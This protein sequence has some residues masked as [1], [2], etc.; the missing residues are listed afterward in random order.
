MRKIH[1]ILRLHFEQKLGQRQ[2]ARSANV[3]Q[4]TVHDYLARMN[5]AGLR[6]PLDQEWDEDR[7]EQALFPPGQAA[8]KAPLRVQPDFVHVRQ[9]LEQHRDLTVELLWEEYREQHPDGYCYSRFCKLYRRWKKHQDVVLRQDHRPGE[10]LFLDWAGATIPIHHRDGT[11]TQAP[12]FVSALGVSSYTYAEAV[13]DQQMANWLKVQMNALEFYDGCPQLL[14]PDNTKT[15][16]TRACIYEPDLNPTYQ[17]FAIHYRV[18]VMPTRP[19]KPR[20]KACVSY[21]T[22]SRLRKG[23]SWLFSSSTA[24]AL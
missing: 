6:W 18:A 14:I 23:E 5:A 4:S 11:V 12:L 10:K 7:L 16:V 2:I 8:A 22:S 1:E 3:S 9:Q 20:D 13:T 15:G 24:L 19:R 21:C 17:E